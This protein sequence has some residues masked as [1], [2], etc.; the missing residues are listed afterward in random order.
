MIKMAGYFFSSSYPYCERM[1]VCTRNS[2][3]GGDI[4]Q[5]FQ[6]PKDL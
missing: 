5:L 4:R 6:I 1:Y 3:E 2:R